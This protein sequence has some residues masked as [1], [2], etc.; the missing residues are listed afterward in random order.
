MLVEALLIPEL[1]YTVVRAYWLVASIL[2]SYV[3]RVSAWK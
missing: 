2:K 3:T 1:V